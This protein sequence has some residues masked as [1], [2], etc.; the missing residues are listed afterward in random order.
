MHHFLVSCG[1]S[2]R[3]R[4]ENSV[5]NVTSSSTY[6]NA[7]HRSY[8][9]LC[10]NVIYLFQVYLCQEFYSWRE[11]VEAAETL[12]FLTEVN[13]ELQRLASIS[14]HLI[15]VLTSFVNYKT[16]STLTPSKSDEVRK[17]LIQA[18]FRV[19]T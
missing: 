12:A 5:Q 3:R 13:V 15:I 10:D 9:E 6:T 14:N 16:D 8:V 4:S 17:E 1:R 11:R 18:A 19:G 2:Y 7:S